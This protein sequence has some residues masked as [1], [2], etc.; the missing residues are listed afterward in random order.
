MGRCE[1]LTSA[2]A[3][4]SLHSGEP[5]SCFS[6]LTL[7]GDP[8]AEEEARQAK[9]ISDMLSERM[10]ASRM[11]GKEKLARRVGEGLARTFG[12]SNLETHLAEGKQKFAE[13]N[14]RRGDGS[15]KGATIEDANHQS[16]TKETADSDQSDDTADK[17]QDL[18][19]GARSTFAPRKRERVQLRS[20]GLDATTADKGKAVAKNRTEDGQQGLS[21]DLV[22]GTGLHTRS[23]P[24]RSVPMAGTASL[25]ELRRDNRAPDVPDDWMAAIN[26]QMEQLRVDF[27]GTE[28]MSEGPR[29]Q[30]KRRS[31]KEGRRH[32]KDGCSLGRAAD[33]EAPEKWSETVSAADSEN[34]GGA[35]V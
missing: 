22:T 24:T 5:D 13:Y 7:W 2:L 8:R 6:A 32:A 17:V 15:A 16:S 28:E 31:R 23:R 10:T 1:G 9:A 26:L 35:G 29:V 12:N 11:S 18:P 4:E 25:A 27:N 19:P 3:I 21:L 14:A 30:P 20:V 34:E 33:A